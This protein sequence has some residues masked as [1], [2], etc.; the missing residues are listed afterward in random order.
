MNSRI[1]K[2]QKILNE[3]IVKR[4]KEAL[5]FETTEA[6][7]RYESYRR[8]VMERDKFHEYTYTAVQVARMI[9]RLSAAEVNSIVAN[10]RNG[11]DILHTEEI[12]RLLW[13]KRSDLIKGYNELNNYYRM[14]LG[15]PDLD[16]P[17]EN[18]IYVED[19]IPIHE[20]SV[21]DINMM[22]Y[23]G[24]LDIIIANHP[25]K[26]YRYLKHLG[27]NIS[28]FQAREARQFEILFLENTEDCRRYRKFYNEERKSF[29]RT[30]TSKH[31]NTTT[32]FN[33]AYE[34][35]CIKFMALVNMEISDYAP[36]VNKNS[37]TVDEAVD[38]WKEFGLSFPKDMPQAYRNTTTF[39]LNYLSLFKGTNYVMEFISERLFTGLKLYKYY[40]TKKPKQNLTYPIPDDTN[41]WEI[42]DVEFILKPYNSFITDITDSEDKVLTYADVVERDPKWRDSEELKRA[43]FSEDFSYVESKYLGLNFY[44]DL[45]RFSMDFSTMINIML[46]NKEILK[47]IEVYFASTGTNEKF[48]DMFI[49]FLALFG[50]LLE[51]ISVVDPNTMDKY[52]YTH[53]YGFNVPSDMEQ[54]R[55]QFIKF[56]I[57]TPYKRLLNDFPK[58]I[59]DND[60]FIEMV[61]KMD[62]QIRILEKFDELIF[63]C[64]NHQDSEF[65][66]RLTKLVTL[67]RANPKVLDMNDFTVDG[68][69]YVQYLE[70]TNPIL[71]SAYTYLLSVGIEQNFTMEFDNVIQILIEALEDANGTGPNVIKLQNLLNDSSVFVNGIN[72]YLLFILKTFKSYSSDFLTEEADFNLT[73]QRNYALQIDQMDFDVDV[74]IPIYYNSTQIDELLVEKAKTQFN[75]VNQFVDT[76][77]LNTPYGDVELETK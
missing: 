72:K 67:V 43:V 18:F 73:T 69:S 29:M 54:F 65:I 47:K 6:T 49:Y 28:A 5:A 71:Y 20:L 27:K 33:E 11:Y 58:A 13:V 10:P 36:I 19:G 55:V 52:K 22:K 25:G 64:T 30:Y 57:N 37:Y 4:E 34:L 63:L 60:S 32:D 38:R 9:P 42:Y 17:P 53:L 24:E 14:L 77:I 68:K 51:R 26:E 62:D 56:F 44:V 31:L 12:N 75:T 23:T 61:C 3:V 21:G 59:T 50:Y 15:L 8:A 39:V 2:M 48:F 45:E 40:I 76:I 41:P 74:E 16:T 46:N 7:D 1:Q 66:Q 35:N 70:E